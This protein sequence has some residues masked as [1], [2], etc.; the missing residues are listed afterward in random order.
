M[1]GILMTVFRMRQPGKV[2][3][4][5]GVL[6]FFLNLYS[7]DLSRSDNEFH[8][9]PKKF[10]DGWDVSSLAAEGLSGGEI[11]EVTRLIRDIDSYENVL[12]MLIV[13]NG[14]LVH[15]VYSPYCQ[16]NTLHWMASITKTITSTLIGIAIDRGFI[17]SVDTKLYELLPQF[18]G[19]FKAPQ[20]REIALKHMMSMTSGL[21]WNER[22][23]YNNP[24]NSEWQMVE[25][26]DWMS[27]VA[28]KPV[29]DSPGTRFNYNTGGL[30][31]LSAAIKN[32]T[33]MFAHEFAEKY[34]LHPMGVY[35]YQW[36]KDP[37]GYPCMGGTD[38]GLGLRTRDIAK[39]GWL[40]LKNG[41]WKGKRII[42]EEW[43]REVPYVQVTGHGRGN[44]YGF[45]WMT[46]SRAANG[47]RFDYIASFGYGGQTLYIVPEHDL[48]IV[49]TCELAGEDS[50]VN[51]LV[52]KTFEA[53]IQN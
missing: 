33:G 24:Q 45:N 34:L 49:F 27:Y 50:G 17:E 16:R 39:F 15:E 9:T 46:G 26:E 12:S 41:R 42:S 10:N 43:I 30:H 28:S 40:F 5:F 1:W 21:D 47:K 2:L 32:A 37:M 20:K 35:A 6:A 4:L 13:K 31:L 19:E 22:V 25:S 11:E 7:A 38:G 23:S 44:R 53:L 29:K 52:A 14:K 18:G 36:N 8:Q 51:T 3:C 48:I